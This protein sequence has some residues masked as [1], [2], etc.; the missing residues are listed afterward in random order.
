[1][2]SHAISKTTKRRAVQESIQEGHEVQPRVEALRFVRPDAKCG[3]FEL[4]KRVAKLRLTPSE[5][6]H[7]SELWHSEGNGVFFDALLARPIQ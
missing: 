7:L 6:E 3:L 4:G 5:R 2:T 1:M